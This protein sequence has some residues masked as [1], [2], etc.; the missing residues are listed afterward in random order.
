MK[1]KR[2]FPKEGRIKNSLNI[3]KESENCRFRNENVGETENNNQFGFG[4][5]NGCSE[6]TKIDDRP[7]VFWLMFLD[8]DFPEF[9]GPE[10]TPERVC[11]IA[12]TA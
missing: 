6:R 4:S 2:Y 12:E 7:R 3:Y 10:N 9:G 1:S 5:A 11:T 8:A